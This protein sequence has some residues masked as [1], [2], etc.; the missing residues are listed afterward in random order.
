[1]NPDFTIDKQNLV[2]DKQHF[3]INHSWMYSIMYSNNTLKNINYEIKRVENELHIIEAI[4]VLIE[5]IE[6]VL[7]AKDEEN[8]EEWIA[9]TF[10]V[11]VVEGA[12][13]VKMV[14]DDKKDDSE[15]LKL[16]HNLTEYLIY[17]KSIN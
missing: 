1:M 17:L 2:I 16:Y 8:F 7:K 14:I 12:E 13:F 3:V 9:S 11:S 10:D 6:D 4:L 5:K 15:I